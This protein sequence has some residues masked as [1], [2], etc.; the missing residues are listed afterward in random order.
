[1][2]GEEVEGRRIQGVDLVTPT[3]DDAAV[4]ASIY[5]L[6]GGSKGSSKGA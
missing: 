1:M 6:W 5:P 4:F 2:G 3:L